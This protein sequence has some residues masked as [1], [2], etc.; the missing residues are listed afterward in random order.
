MFCDVLQ[1][2]KPVSYPENISRELR[3]LREKQHSGISNG[4]VR[5][6]KFSKINRD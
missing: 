2:S 3:K 1:K 6:Q 5:F 4:I